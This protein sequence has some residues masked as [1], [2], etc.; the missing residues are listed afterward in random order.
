MPRVQRIDVDLDTWQ[1]GPANRW[2]FQHLDEFLATAPVWRGQGPVRE[3]KAGT[4]EPWSAEV[5]DF[6]TESCTDGILVLRGD[7]VLAET[8]LNDMTPATRHLFM[9]VSKSL[10]SAV[11]GQYVATGEIDCSAVVTTYLPELADSAYGDATVQE[12]LDMTVGVQFDETYDDP[13]SEVQ[14]QDRV[15]GWRTPRPGDPVDSYAFMATLRRS[16]EHGRTFQYCSANTDVLA[17][18]LER[19]TGVGYA[20]LLSSRLWQRLGAEH[21]AYVTVD[22]SGFP[23]ANGGVC[24]TLRDLAR[25]GRLVLDD[26]VNHVGDQV[27]PASWLADTRAGGDP[28]AAVASMGSVHPNGSYRNQFWISGDADGSFY[29]VGIHGQYIWMNPAAD[30]VVAKLST[31]PDADSESDWTAHIQFFDRLRSQ[32]G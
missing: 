31:L 22:R 16:G 18:I 32:F 24:A 7:T 2:A 13:A 10:C 15:A 5:E 3:L 28:A 23:M 26:G 4:Q 6:L 25:F 20:E 29:G 1:V 11:V 21:D 27:I 19:V 30:L 17:W 9:S 8:Y 12:V 14:T